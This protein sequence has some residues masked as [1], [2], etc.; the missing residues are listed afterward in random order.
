MTRESSSDGAP[1][2]YEVLGVSSDAPAAEISR[3]YRRRARDLHPDASDDPAAE[4]RFKQLGEAYAVLRDPE[5]RADYDRGL[6]VR[7][8]GARRRP[9]G[10]YTI[11]VDRVG[12]RDD[13]AIRGSVDASLTVPITFAEAV[14]GAELSVPAPS[15]TVRLRIPPGTPSGRVFRLRGHGPPGDEGRRGDLFVTVQ[16]HVPQ[17]L[18][19]RQREL[20]EALARAEDPELIRAHLGVG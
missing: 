9:D 11:R 5:A 6:T 1:D 20:I 4:E 19:S 8:G 12:P 7:R 14:R 10:G 3:A 13:A 15:G 2:L 18:T 16:I 17:H